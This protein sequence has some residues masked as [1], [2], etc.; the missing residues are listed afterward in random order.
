MN[1]QRLTIGFGAL[2]IALGVISYAA[3]DAASITALFPAFAGVPIVLAGL[4]MGQPGRRKPGL[5]AALVFV[6]LLAVG[7]LRGVGLLFGTLGG[8]DDVTLAMIVQTVIVV[9]GVIYL[10]FG[11]RAV[12]AER[13]AS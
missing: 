2:L 4:L 9:L 5:Y 10:V 1:M 3:S 12:M 8:D 6:L 13:R 7:S 11:V